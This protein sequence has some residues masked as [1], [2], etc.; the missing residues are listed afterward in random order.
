MEASAIS[1]RQH[2]QEIFLVRWQ[3]TDGLERVPIRVHSGVILMQTDI[4]RKKE[5]EHTSF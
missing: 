1:S 4:T 5:S 3:S 2:L